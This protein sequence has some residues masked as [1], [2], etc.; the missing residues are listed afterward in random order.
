MTAPPKNL[1]I[2]L[3]HVHLQAMALTSL[4]G[5]SSIELPRVNVI[6]D[7]PI[8][9]CKL[10]KLPASPQNITYLKFHLLPYSFGASFYDASVTLQRRTTIREPSNLDAQEGFLP[11]HGRAT[12]QKE[13]DTCTDI[14]SGDLCVDRQYK[15]LSVALAQSRNDRPCLHLACLSQQCTFQIR[16]ASAPITVLLSNVNTSK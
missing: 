1:S 2:A 14:L 12:K 15:V 16:P 11:C 5:S 13:A 3:A 8:A 9:A 7:E 6:S 4:R 10:S